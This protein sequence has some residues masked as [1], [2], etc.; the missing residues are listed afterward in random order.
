[1][2]Y[3][4]YIISCVAALAL[5]GCADTWDEHYEPS[6][7]NGTETLLQLV[8]SDSQLSD[9][10]KLLEATHLYNNV[11]R[12]PVTY[13]EF[14]ASDQ[15][16]TVWA[17]VNG[18]FNIDSLME[19]CQ[20]EQGDSSVAQ[21]FVANHISRNLYN[22]NSA[23]S[24]SV[25]M[26][27]DKF[28]GLTP[29]TLGLSPVD[30]ACCN[31]P[32]KNGILHKLTKE[33]PYLYNVYEGLTSLPQYS[34]I[35]DYI[36][37]YEK[38]EL[39]E[40]NSVVSGLEEGKKVYSDSVMYQYNSLF[41]IFDY[42]NSEDSTFFMLAPNKALWDEQYAKAKKYFNYGNVEKADSLCGY[43]TNVALIQD[44]IY[45]SNV[46][47]SVNDSI[48]S[49]AYS[50]LTWPYHR[51][52][53]PF[54]EDGIITRADIQSYQECSNGIIY[55]IGSW[56]FTAEELYFRPITIQ[57]EREANLRT[58]KDCTFNYRSVNNEL[59]SGNGYLDIV[60]AK[61]TSNWTAVFELANTLS[62]SY[63]VC[64]VILPK[65]VYLSNSKDTK[66]NKFTASVTYL[67]EEGKEKTTSFNTAV[68]NDG[69]SVDTVV[70]GRVDLP[71]CGYGLQN[72]NV[73]LTLKCN[74]GTR[75]TKFSREMFLDCIYMKPVTEEEQASESNSRKEVRK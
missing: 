74:V 68:Q 17:P 49:T 60:P 75:E 54:G 16:L 8:K 7:G 41:R 67:D 52:Y 33:A 12:T 34:H 27:N 22:M 51:Y 11:R 4:S 58:K 45:N 1:M 44:L 73:I 24:E 38:L 70:I 42:I 66:P 56:P 26:L 30:D 3:K 63:D 15:T 9:F 10:N 6:L 37:K 23:T 47:R 53:Y 71:V 46:Q 64:A 25:R 18:S 13:S 59:V 20:T 55:N 19:L 21:H 35:G 69:V 28:L 5:A 57:A 40:K 31:V 65:T 48:F 62:G 32:A 39:D 61:S 14:L 72:T 36:R 29:T 43:W 2:K 50:P